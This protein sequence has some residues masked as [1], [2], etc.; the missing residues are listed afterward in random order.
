[1]VTDPVCTEDLFPTLLGLSGLRPRD[2]KPGLDLTPVA[3][4]DV[5]ASFGHRYAVAYGLL[6]QAER[7]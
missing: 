4:G 2:P 1:M 6:Q 5:A 7:T 3:R